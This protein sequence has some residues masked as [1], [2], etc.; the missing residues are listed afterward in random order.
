MA[1]TKYQVL[2]RY[3]NPNSNQFVL[4]DVEAP[5]KECLEFYHDMHKNAIGT[6]DEKLEANTEQ[7]DFIIEGNNTANDNYN[8]LF[9]FAG[10]KRINKKNWMPASTGYLIRDKEAIR[11]QITRAVDGDFSG[12]YLLMEGD[13]IENG[14]VVAK[15]NPVTKNI[16]ITSDNAAN[17]TYFKND[18]E[19]KS[20]IIHSTIAQ[21]AD[22][23]TSIYGKLD[24]FTGVNKSGYEHINIKVGSDF[25]L[26]D[27]SYYTLNTYGSKVSHT[28]TKALENSTYASI[29]ANGCN[30]YTSVTITPSHV[31]TYEIPAHYEEVAEYP[32][33]I[34]DTY[35]RI[36][37]SPWFVLSTHA[38]FQSAIE[39][40]KAIVKTVGIDNVKLIK[41]VP[42]DQFIKTK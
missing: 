22:T 13:S 29:V 8:M 16:S 17:K 36:E 27:I 42:T 2:Y 10:T 6:T 14:V 11:D 24:K 35:K 19:L 34:C 4:N 41:V 25:V 9:K 33:I 32:Y 1:A 23:E 12:D 40:V 21:L 26:N 38:S 39:K 31:Q 37:Q 3:T 28:A 18:D 30:A 5:Y 15:K 7:S 20:V